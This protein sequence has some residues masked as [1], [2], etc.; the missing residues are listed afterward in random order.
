MARERTLARR[1]RGEVEQME[2]WNTFQEMERM[3]R[4]FFIS[5]HPLIQPPRWLSELR[6][7]YMPDVDLKETEKEFILSATI[8][9]LSKDDVDIDVTDD[10]ITIC[11]ERKTEEEKP[12]E[13]YHLR[14]QNYG[15]FRVSYALPSDVKPDDVKA[16][17]KNGIF[18]VVLPKAEVHEAHKVKVEGKD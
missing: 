4:N 11:G 14:Q 16:T 8:P 10:R 3:F 18:N 7:E 12:G 13:R 9:G 2:P 1:E 15:M 17:Y 5:P 6:T